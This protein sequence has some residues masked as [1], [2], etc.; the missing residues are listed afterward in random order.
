[1][2]TLLM[3]TGI[4]V[5]GLVGVAL[6]SRRRTGRLGINSQLPACPVCG[7]VPSPLRWPTSWRQALWG[8]WTCSHCGTEFD[9]WGTSIAK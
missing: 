7:T 8:G 4:A 9:K 2:G 1:M 3:L 6:A 5:V